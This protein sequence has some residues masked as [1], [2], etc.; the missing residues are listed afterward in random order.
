[1]FSKLM[2]YAIRFSYHLQ[3]NEKECYDLTFMMHD[4]WKYK[5]RLDNEEAINGVLSHRE[6]R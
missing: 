2:Q 6:H 1:M 4:R 5:K 3:M